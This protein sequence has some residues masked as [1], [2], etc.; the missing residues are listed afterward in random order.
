MNGRLFILPGFLG[1][2]DKEQI[3]IPMYQLELVKHL[4][5]IIAENAKT[6]RAFIKA[7]QFQHPLQEITVREMNKHGEND[8]HDMMA[9]LL[10]GQDMGL[11]S[12]AG[13]PCIADPGNTFVAF[14][15]QK[16]IEVIPLIGPSSIMLALM[17]SGFNGQQFFFHG[18]IPVKDPER[19]KAIKK[20]DEQSAHATQI[21]IETPYRNEAILEA[22]HRNLN[23]QTSVCIACNLLQKDQRILRLKAKDIKGTDLQFLHKKPCVFLLGK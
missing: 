11:M 10:T 7:Y 19:S 14:A 4:K 18:Y 21:F 5:H 20:M 3:P 13:L 15:H 16:N 8:L 1:E 23:A 17:T 2:A 22:L 6:A 12:E 9:P